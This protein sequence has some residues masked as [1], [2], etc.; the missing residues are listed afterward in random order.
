MM[1]YNNS[2]DLNNMNWMVS[3]NWA[4]GLLSVANFIQ[5]L[6]KYFIYLRNC[7]SLTTSLT[8]NINLD[9][10]VPHDNKI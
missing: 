5:L 8:Q 2:K 1:K 7:I 4:V 6:I 10:C 9:W 3:K